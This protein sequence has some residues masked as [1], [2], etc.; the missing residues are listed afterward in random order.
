VQAQ[1]TIDRDR[2]VVGGRTIQIDGHQL[3]W[4]GYV[5]TE[6]DPASIKAAMYKSRCVIVR[7]PRDLR[8]RMAAI[9]LLDAATGQC[10]AAY[11]DVDVISP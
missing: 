2:I 4:W 5:V 8:P 11:W 10:F 3:N 1:S 6:P 9:Y 7:V